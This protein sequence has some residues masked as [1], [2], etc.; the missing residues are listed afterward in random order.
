MPRATYPIIFKS[1][2]SLAP[3]MD[4]ILKSEYDS[5]ISDTIGAHA[6]RMW[7]IEPR[8]RG[9]LSRRQKRRQGDRLNRQKQADANL[10]KR[11]NDGKYQFAKPLPPKRTYSVITL[12]SGGQATVEGN[13]TEIL[14]TIS[15]AQAGEP[16]WFVQKDGRE[17]YIRAG[18]I[19]SVTEA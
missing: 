16:L 4:Y 14:Q 15:G 6:N 2:P 19:A 12:V 3:Q 11:H 5:A 18:S 13:P 9:R 10:R 17:S 1:P 7:G 8:K